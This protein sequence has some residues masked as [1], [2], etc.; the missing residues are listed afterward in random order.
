MSNKEHNENFKMVQLI[1][2]KSMF[3]NML[4][5]VLGRN[6]IIRIKNVVLL[7]IYKYVF[8]KMGGFYNCVIG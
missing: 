7:P 1:I 5:I 6:N 8:L 3:T 2:Y 4:L